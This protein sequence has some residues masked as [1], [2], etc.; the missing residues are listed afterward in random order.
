[1]TTSENSSSTLSSG[2][3]RTRRCIP[4]TSAVQSSSWA[5]GFYALE[6]LAVN[7]EARS[8]DGHR[9]FDSMFRGPPLLF[10]VPRQFPLRASGHSSAKYP[11]KSALIYLTVLSEIFVCS[12]WML[13]RPHGSAGAG[14]PKLPR[15]SRLY[16]QIQFR[17]SAA[18]RPTK[19]AMLAYFR[20]SP[21]P[22]MKTTASFQRNRQRAWFRRS[23]R[24]ASFFFLVA[25]GL[26]PSGATRW[27]VEVRYGP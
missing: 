14:W 13:K 5:T 22:W 21:L 10:P 3:G 4:S 11:R 18:W 23:A 8:P 17:S 19:T 16:P 9:R 12:M 1:M 15:T 24:L 25:C 20:Y 6:P 7:W 2:S 26:N 27:E